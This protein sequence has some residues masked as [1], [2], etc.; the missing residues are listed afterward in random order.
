MSLAVNRCTEILN[1][2]LWYV[3]MFVNIGFTVSVTGSGE[4]LSL[5]FIFGSM[6]SCYDLIDTRGTSWLSP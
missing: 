1:Q 2:R 5:F 4:D 6:V 3:V